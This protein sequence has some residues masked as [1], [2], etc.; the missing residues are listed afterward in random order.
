MSVVDHANSHILENLFHHFAYTFSIDNLKYVDNHS[1]FLDLLKKY[2]NAFEQSEIEELVTLSLKHC[3]Q[4]DFHPKT[5]YEGTFFHLLSLY[6]NHQKAK[7]QRIASLNPGD[8]DCPLTIPMSEA[9]LKSLLPEHTYGN[10]D[11]EHKAAKYMDELKSLVKNI[12]WESLIFS[13]I[14]DFYRSVNCKIIIFL[15]DHWLRDLYFLN[16]FI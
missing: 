7:Y 3:C 12:R 15:G 14:T 6:L 9:R 2:S 10:K 4:L 16:E 1:K 13:G 8:K 11:F 5:V